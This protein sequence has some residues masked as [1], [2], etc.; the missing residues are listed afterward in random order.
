MIC[1]SNA[2]K[3]SQRIAKSSLER[4]RLWGCQ[5]DHQQSCELAVA[6]RSAVPV[7]DLCAA[8]EGETRWKHEPRG[9]RG[10]GRNS[11][12][13]RP[14]VHDVHACYCL[15]LVT[16]SSCPAQRSME[17]YIVLLNVLFDDLQVVLQ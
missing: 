15:M 14:M 7:D 10:Y 5:V 11:G 12:L 9:C 1:S 6:F 4:L 3:I 17:S 16:V 13:G 8:L 2:A